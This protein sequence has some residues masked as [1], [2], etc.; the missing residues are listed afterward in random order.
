MR[1]RG[2]GLVIKTSS[3]VVPINGTTRPDVCEIV[4]PSKY[5]FL[6]TDSIYI[7]CYTVLILNYQ[8]SKHSYFTHCSKHI[9]FVKSKKKSIQNPR[10]IFSI[11][12]VNVGLFI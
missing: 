3:F 8:N 2:N 11:F 7:R 10:R 4:N 6:E 1:G 5:I 9:S 12:L